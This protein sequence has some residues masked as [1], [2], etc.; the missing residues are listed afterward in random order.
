MES[1]VSE[2]RSGLDSRASTSRE[3][4]ED[5]AE[6]EEE[7]GLDPETREVYDLCGDAASDDSQAFVYAET[8]AEILA[9]MDELTG[10]NVAAVETVQTE[11][12]PAP[13]CIVGTEEVW[14]YEPQYG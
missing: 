6:E 7:D 12:G 14:Y 10:D 2:A 9:Q 1:D 4:C 5:S 3:V 13:D 8:Q 11:S